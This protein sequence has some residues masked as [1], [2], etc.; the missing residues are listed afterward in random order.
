MPIEATE[1]LSP[2]RAIL[3]AIILHI[4][5]LQGEHFCDSLNKLADITVTGAHLYGNSVRLYSGQEFYEIEINHFVQDGRRSPIRLPLYNVSS[6][7]SELIAKKPMVYKYA[8]HTSH[9]G[10]VDM[11]GIVNWTLFQIDLRIQSADSAHNVYHLNISKKLVEPANTKLN[12]LNFSG[13]LLSACSCQGYAAFRHNEKNVFVRL[14]NILDTSNT[15]RMLDTHGRYITKCPNSEGA[16]FA[17]FSSPQTPS[18]QVYSTEKIVGFIYQRHVYVFSN[19]HQRV[20]IFDFV[21][22]LDEGSDLNVHNQS[23][24]SFLLCSPPEQTSPPSSFLARLGIISTVLLVLVIVLL[25]LFLIFFYGCPKRTAT[26]IRTFSYQ[27]MRQ[28]RAHS[29]QHRGHPQVAMHRTTHTNSTSTS[30]TL[31][32]TRNAPRW[33]HTNY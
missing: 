30:T 10:W 7:G 19:A 11:A 3:V 32:P 23:Y 28:H 12:N 20:H 9:I 4:S 16:C 31:A 17:N 8:A 24:H 25:I 22:N 15:A 1:M 29:P 21:P 26:R 18:V 5:S 2:Y 6:S 27:R 33:G 13:L 14:E